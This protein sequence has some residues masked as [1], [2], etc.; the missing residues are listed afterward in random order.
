MVPDKPPAHYHWQIRLVERSDQA[1]CSGS[2][3]R[4][5]PEPRQPD[6]LANMINTDRGKK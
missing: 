6:Q 5:Y 2:H 3:K 1:L 4:L